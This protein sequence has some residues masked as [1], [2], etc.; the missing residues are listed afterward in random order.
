MKRSKPKFGHNQPPEPIEHDPTLIGYVRVSTDEQNADMQIHALVR[1]GVHPDNIH[2]DIGVSGVAPRRPGREMALKQ[3]REGDT[4]VVWKLDRVTRSLLDLL[5]LLQDLDKR[6]IGFV[7]LHDVFDTR[8]P[9]GKAMLALAGIFAE[10]ERD[11][12]KQRT[13]AGIA[14]AKARG[15]RFGQPTKITDDIRTKIDAWL[16]EGLS[17][18]AI[19]KR[20]KSSGTKLAE[21]TI[22]KYWKSEQIARARAGKR[23]R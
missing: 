3:M 22:R 2:Q 18:P 17:V 6:G 8:T 19:V 5:L 15:V 23:N 11:L 10:L 1:R 4:L 21:S 9:M 16:Y 13:E 12:I 20:F 14:R 7:S